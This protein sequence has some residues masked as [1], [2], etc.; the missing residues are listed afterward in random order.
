[1]P[2]RARLRS[3]AD[4]APF[5]EARRVKENACGDLVSDY[6]ARDEYLHG[7]EIDKITEFEEIYDRKPEKNAGSLITVAIRQEC[8]GE[9]YLR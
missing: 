2:R 5:Q 4:G 6:R 3:E 7:P 8:R 1:V 9:V